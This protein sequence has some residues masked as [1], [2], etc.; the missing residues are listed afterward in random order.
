M[1]PSPTFLQ[2]ISF[3]KHSFS[4]CLTPESRYQKIMEWG[5]ELKDF[6]AKWKTPENLVSGCQSLMYLHA[7]GTEKSL[8][9]KAS[10]DA[11][12]SAGLAALLIYAYSGES[13]EII[14]R[15]PPTFL[16]ELGIPQTLTPSRANG[17]A[18]L[19]QK[20]KQLALQ[21]LLKRP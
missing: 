17:L 20:M 13:A 2:K 4:T 18:A 10:S 7:T 16:E 19:Y 1:D 8:I 21:T 11:L 15:V 3:I 6:D 5:K 9:F 12:I 14:L